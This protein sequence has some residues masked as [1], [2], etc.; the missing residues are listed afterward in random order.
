MATGRRRRNARAVRRLALPTV[1]FALG[2]S[3]CARPPKPL[4]GEFPPLSVADAREGAAGIAVRWGGKIVATRPESGRTCLEI[5]RH[6]LDGQ[7]RP[8]ATD[9]TDGRFVACAPGFYEPALYAAGREVTVVG[10]VNGVTGGRVGEAEY[11][12]PRVDARAVHLWEERPESAYYDPGPRIGIS[13]GG[14]FGF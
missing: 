5:V 3:A 11:R 12:F 14:I 1:V 9:E 7:A 8:R 2:L 4:A 6:P 13:I 10:T